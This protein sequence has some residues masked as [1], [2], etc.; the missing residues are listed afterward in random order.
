M[1]EKHAEKRTISSKGQVVVPKKIRDYLEVKDGDQLEFMIRETGEVVLTPVKS[2]HPKD[3][4]GSLP[5]RS[6][7]TQNFEQVLNLAKKERFQKRKQ[8][9]KF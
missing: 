2:E 1:K 9:G 8:E 6:A 3:L 7:D 4:F 5:A